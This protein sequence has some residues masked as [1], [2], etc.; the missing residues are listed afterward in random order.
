MFGSVNSCLVPWNGEGYRRVAP[1]V[2]RPEGSQH[3][4]SWGFTFPRGSPAHLACGSWS[5][6]FSLCDWSPLREEQQTQCWDGSWQGWASSCLSSSLSP[7]LGRTLFFS[8]LRAASSLRAHK[9]WATLGVFVAIWG[10][11]IHYSIES[12]I[13]WEQGGLSFHQNKII[14]HLVNT[15]ERKIL[16]KH[17]PGPSGLFCFNC[18]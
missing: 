18:A 8:A 13:S 12:L 9:S 15:Q 6:W 2:L 11:W 3:R 1:K 17:L 4:T 7:F 14:R 10:T 5:K 16:R